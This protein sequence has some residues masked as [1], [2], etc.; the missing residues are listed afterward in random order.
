M[1]VM[2]V[3]MEIDISTSNTLVEMGH[4]SHLFTSLILMV[5][6]YNR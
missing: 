3:Q 1:T 5:K 4:I 6:C 2:T